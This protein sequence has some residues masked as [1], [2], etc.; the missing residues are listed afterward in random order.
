MACLPDYGKIDCNLCHAGRKVEFN[1]TVSHSDD[2]NWRITANPLS[3]GSKN[4]AIVV[5]GFSKGANAVAALRDP[6]KTIEDIPYAGK[7]HYVAKILNSIGLLR[8]KDATDINREISD[9]SSIFHFGSLV[10]CTVEQRVWDDGVETW[11]SSG[12]QMLEKFSAHTFGQDV[13][14]NCTVRFLAQLPKTVKLIVMF[15]LGADLAKGGRRF[16]YV[17]NAKKLLSEVRGHDMQWL[18][19]VS[20]YDE[21]LVILHT[22]HFSGRNHLEHWLGRDH[23][24]RELR[25]QA[26]DAVRFAMQRIG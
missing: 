7:R 10:R 13:I 20:Y 21:D 3:W 9:T 18:N 6:K 8:G 23:P 1:R 11:V 25:H 26:I 15:G 2:G 14:S 22:D 16:S 24:R 12:S 4:P 5:L 19:D 17:E